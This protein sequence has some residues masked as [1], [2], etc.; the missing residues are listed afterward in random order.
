MRSPELE[1]RHLASAV[2]HTMLLDVMLGLLESYKHDGR[3]NAGSAF[4]ERMVVAVVR[5]N[6][7]FGRPPANM[8]TIAKRLRNHRQNVARWL[9][10]LLEFG[11]LLRSGRYGFIGNDQYLKERIDAP[12]WMPVVKAII[13]AGKLLEEIYPELLS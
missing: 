13:K 5:E 7:G 12:Y 9:K 8:S 11:V 2:V 10:P 4:P 1:K 6:D 3:R